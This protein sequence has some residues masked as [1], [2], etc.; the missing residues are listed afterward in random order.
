VFRPGVDDAAVPLLAFPRPE[1]RSLADL[2][3]GWTRPAVVPGRP[4][5]RV[6]N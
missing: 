4:R 5:V 1:W 6:P 3:R 2:G